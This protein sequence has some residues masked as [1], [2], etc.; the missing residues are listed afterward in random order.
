M[1]RSKPARRIWRGGIDESSATTASCYCAVARRLRR[2]TSA[3]PILRFSVWFALRFVRYSIVCTANDNSRCSRQEKHT[4]YRPGKHSSGMDFRG[5][6]SS[7]RL[8]MY[9]QKLE[10]PLW[11]FKAASTLIA[12]QSL[13]LSS[14]FVLSPQ[15]LTQT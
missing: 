8:G 14:N 2:S 5:L 10:L 6:D 15:Y 1:E 3:W 13:R 9:C 7:P 4:W 12:L 11:N